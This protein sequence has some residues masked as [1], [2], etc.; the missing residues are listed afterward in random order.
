MT[1][2]VFCRKLQRRL[3]GLSRPPFPGPQ[4]QEI[5]ENI[6]QQAW[7]DWVE[8]QTM[9]INENQLKTSDVQAREW[10]ATQREAFFSGGD[11]QRPQGYIPPE[12]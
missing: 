9:L 11:Y 2:E 7:N 12:G 3:P 10:L 4:G 6:S 8:L 5:H 1:S